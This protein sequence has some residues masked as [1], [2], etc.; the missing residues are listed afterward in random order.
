MHPLLQRLRSLNFYWLTGLGLL[1]WMLLFDANDL[2][3]QA[4]M[5]YRLWQLHREQAYYRGQIK[6]VERQHR[7]VMGTPKLMEKFAREKYFMKK[8]GED[9][10]VI[11]D[12]NNEPL[13]K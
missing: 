5:H 13:E 7:E 1:A 6:D 3:T 12:E 9:V 2:I 11:V 4:R 8:P 10:F